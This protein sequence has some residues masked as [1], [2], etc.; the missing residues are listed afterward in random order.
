M[1]DLLRGVSRFDWM[2]QERWARGDQDWP[3]SRYTQ[4]ELADGCGPLAL[5][6]YGDLPQ[7][8]AVTNGQVFGYLSYKMVPNK[9]VARAD[10]YWGFDPYRFDH[11]GTKQAVRWVLDYFGLELN[12]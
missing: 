4:Q 10:V 11:A 6:A 8:S 2:R 1:G 9:P 12:P 3:D 5:A 7:G